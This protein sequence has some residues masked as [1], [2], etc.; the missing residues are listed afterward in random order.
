ML[1]EEEIIFFSLR[2]I[3]IRKAMRPI[4]LSNGWGLRWEEPCS[5]K[6][7]FKNNMS[8]PLIRDLCIISGPCLA[9]LPRMSASP[10]CSDEDLYYLLMPHHSLWRYILLSYFVTSSFMSFFFSCKIKDAKKKWFCLSV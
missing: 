5:D 8:H 10:L 9:L 4:G 3:M 7:C 6:K 2:L 1:G